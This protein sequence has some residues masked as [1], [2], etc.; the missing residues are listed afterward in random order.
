VW[1]TRDPVRDVNGLRLL[2]PALSR[3]AQRP[4]FCSSPAGL[5]KSRSWKMRR[6][7]RFC[8]GQAEGPI[9]DLGLHGISG[10]SRPPDWLTGYRATCHWLSLDQLGIFGVMPVKERVVDRSQ[11]DDRRGGDVGIDFALTLVASLFR[12]KR[13]K[14]RAARHG[15]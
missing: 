7:S 15:I 11:P 10:F 5:D 2:P 4:A 1:K 12:R 6:F 14:T 8:R 13:A 9:C 3:I